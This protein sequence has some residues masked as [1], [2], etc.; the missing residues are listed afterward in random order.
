MNNKRIKKW[1][2]FF[3][4]LSLVAVI[5]YLIAIPHTVSTEYI[6]TRLEHA[7]ITTIPFTQREMLF[8][9]V[10]VFLLVNIP[11]YFLLLYALWRKMRKSNT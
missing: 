8:E 11:N 7:T 9:A 2:L 1:I 10:K 3:F 5:A 4:I 6:H